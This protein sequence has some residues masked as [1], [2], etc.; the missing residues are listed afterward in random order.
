MTSGEDAQQ[1][2]HLILDYYRII[3]EEIINDFN[4]IMED[5]NLNI[6]SNVREE[7][8]YALLE[9]LIPTSLVLYITRP[10]FDGF[11]S[12][13]GKDHYQ[14]LKK[15][16]RRLW[17]KTRNM[18][19][20]FISAGK[21]KVRQKSPYSLNFSIMTVS[22][23]SLL[24]KF[25]FLSSLND[26]EFE[27]TLNEVLN[28]LSVLYSSNLNSETIDA[29]SKCNPPFGKTI[30]LTYDLSQERFIVLRPEEETNPSITFRIRK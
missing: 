30:L 29:L 16:V 4:S 7:K 10:Y 9:W 15:G 5:S 20:K 25:L 27:I 24:F 8:A 11:L 6:V 18:N 22:E 19:V 14:L 23:D 2:P 12:E 26:D 1:N 21:Y 13:M 17:A 28:F 3:P